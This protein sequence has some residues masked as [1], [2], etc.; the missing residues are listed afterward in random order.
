MKKELIGYAN[1]NENMAEDCHAKVGTIRNQ[2]PYVINYI[3]A[4]SGNMC[5]F[6]LKKKSSWRYR[7]REWYLVMPILYMELI[8]EFAEDF[9]WKG[10]V[11]V[12]FSVINSSKWDFWTTKS[13]CVNRSRW[14]QHI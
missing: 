1:T 7:N 2:H 8:F 9:G 4:K 13:S 6:F 12:I 10:P 14:Q 11:L 5:C 3:S